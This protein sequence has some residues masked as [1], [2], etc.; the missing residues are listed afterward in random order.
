MRRTLASFPGG[1]ASGPSGLQP[2]H[3]KETLAP[4]LKD[5]VLRLMADVVNLLLRG[6]APEQV[7]AWLCGASLVA[8]PEPSRDLRPIAVGETWRRLAGKA[9]ATVVAEQAREHLEPLQLGVGSR[10]GAEATEHVVRQ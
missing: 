9:L 7:Q 2:L 1:S 5:E 3:L 10:V 4:G 8:F 6:E